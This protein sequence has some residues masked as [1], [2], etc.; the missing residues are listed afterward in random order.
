MIKQQ[1]VS[2][3]QS[4]HLTER[5]Y[6][7]HEHGIYTFKI[8]INSNKSQV[9]R[10][11]EYVYGVEVENVRVLRYKPEVKRNARGVGRTKAFKK[12]YVRLRSGH[13]ID[14]NAQV[15]EGAK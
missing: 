9:K 8:G 14:I 3:L 10:A 15:V 4:H 12:A 7:L 5:T 11:I 6:A 1:L 13:A 2:V